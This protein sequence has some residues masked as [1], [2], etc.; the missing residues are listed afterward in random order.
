[1][2][3]RGMIK[4]CI[5]DNDEIGLALVREMLNGIKSDEDFD[6]LCEECR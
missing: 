2:N 6:Q 1:M 5:A 3:I 4:V